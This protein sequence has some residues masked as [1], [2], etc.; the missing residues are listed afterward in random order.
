VLGSMNKAK[1]DTIIKSAFIMFI[2]AGFLDKISDLAA[3]LVGGSQLSSNSISAMGM[4][5]KAFGALNG[6]QDRAL[7]ALKKHGKS[8][9]SGAAS[10]IKERAFL[11]SF[12]GFSA[13]RGGPGVGNDAPGSKSEPSG[14]PDSSLKKPDEG[15]STRVQDA[16][17][18]D[19]DAQNFSHASSRSE[20]NAQK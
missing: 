12:K 14:A 18:A 11:Q 3:Q 13:K 5:K 4:A 10:K 2:F 1:L 6:I 7:R 17:P 9:A 19:K 8:A 15:S 16:K 20:D